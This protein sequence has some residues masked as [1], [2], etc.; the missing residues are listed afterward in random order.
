MKT[1]KLNIPAQ[2][3]LAIPMTNDYLFRALLQENNRVLKALIQDLLYLSEGDVVSAE[4]TNPIQLGKSI[5]AKTF[6]LDINVLMNNNAI[7]NIELQ[8]INEHNWVDRSLSY[9]CRNYDNL[10]KGDN[11]EFVSPAYQIG[12]LNFTLFEEAPEF[13]ASYK[14]MNE[15]SHKI[16]SDK[17]QLYV[18]DL[19]Q[20]EMATSE[21]KAHA[22]DYWAKL[23]TAKTWE[24]IH[25][26]AK[27]KPVIQDA[28]ETVYKLSKEEEVRLQ[29]Q[30]R[31]AYYR[32]QH[33]FHG[34]YKNQLAEKD[35]ALAEKDE[36]IAEKELELSQKDNVIA[37]LKRQLEE[38]LAKK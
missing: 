37:D 13:F 18:L 15:K 21:D 23:F 32:A 3:P 11:Y 27:E 19:T 33:A 29:C 20:I 30:A 22:L 36:V 31:E 7:L 17:F 9:L 28:S 10:N 24:E 4:I 8:V 35:E 6:F 38:A 14:I 26:L 2:G 34:Y 5:D 12:L 16:Y 25:M 1:K